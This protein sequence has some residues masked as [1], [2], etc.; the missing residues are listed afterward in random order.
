MKKSTA[1]VLKHALSFTVH[2]SVVHSFTLCRYEVLL[3]GTEEHRVLALNTIR[4]FKSALCLYIPR[5]N[6]YFC[7][8]FE[9]SAP[10][11]LDCSN[12]QCVTE[13]MFFS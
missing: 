13:E 9:S 12:A 7:V 10:F 6:L 2:S 3:S 4:V 11:G 1:A 8:G 5:Q